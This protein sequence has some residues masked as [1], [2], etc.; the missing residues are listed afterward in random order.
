MDNNF[1]IFVII[2]LVLF[3]FGCF[4]AVGI[5][6]DPRSTESTDGALKLKADFDKLT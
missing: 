3:S 6:K 4:L 2:F 1:F 5:T